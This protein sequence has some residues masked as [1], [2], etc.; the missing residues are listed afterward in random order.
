MIVTFK[1]ILIIPVI[2]FGVFLA[3]YF[4]MTSNTFSAG[5]TNNI[6]L[7][8]AFVEVSTTKC[9]ACSNQIPSA[10]YSILAGQSYS[11][12][13]AQALF[14][15]QEGNSFIANNSVTALPS[16][17]MPQTSISANVLS[18][19]VY[20]NM[21]NV[22]SNSFVLNTPFISGLLGKLT[23]FSIIQNRT[24]TVTDIYNVS[25]V[26]GLSRSSPAFYDINPT[27]FL[28]QSNVSNLTKG[29][30]T[31]ILLIYSDS[32]FSAVQSLIIKN[33]L[34]N[35]GNFSGDSTLQSGAISATTTQTIGPEPM[36]NFENMSFNSKIFSFV[37]YNLSSVQDQTA[38]KELF[39]YDQNAISL[40]SIYGS[41][42]PFLD[43]GGKF[44]GV[45]SMLSPLIFNGM[46]ITEVNHTLKTNTTL[47]NLF[48]N[49][50]SFLDATLCYY[51]LGSEAVC[52]TSAVQSQMSNIETAITQ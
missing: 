17:V 21:F 6:N 52:N 45:S 36:Y 50:V 9:Q 29:N 7:N 25:N 44:I 22:E 41:F 37:A 33:A 48:N 4:L 16:V 51:T 47:S 28:M 32:P 40:N 13:Q 46:N 38:Q 30:K 2:L 31:E 27:E 34:Q 23:Y 3:G 19:M 49:A 14:G 26:Y 10:I 42:T 15:T 8:S 43:I 18:A 35:F 20:L 39:Q 24:I 5:S 11:N 12:S 1:F